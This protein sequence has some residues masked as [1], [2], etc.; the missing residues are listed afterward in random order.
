MLGGETKVTVGGKEYTFGKV[1]LPLI[2]ALGDWIKAQVGDPFAR[3]E[4]LLARAEQMPPGPI[5]DLLLRQYEAAHAE[6]K[7]KAQQLEFFDLACPLAQKAMRTIRGGA[8]W[9][10]LML[11]PAHPGISEQ[12]AFDVLTALGEEQL[13]EITQKGMGKV[14]KNGAGPG[15]GNPARRGSN[16]PAV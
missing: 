14:P 13:A 4:S 6:G 10:Q 2:Y 16:L 11:E 9:C 1:S 3:A 15:A 7:D 5:Q 12:E 8:K